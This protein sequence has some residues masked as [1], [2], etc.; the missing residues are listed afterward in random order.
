MSA[1]CDSLVDQAGRLCQ[2]HHCE[3]AIG[4]LEAAV[5]LDPKSAILHY[6]LGFCYS[7]GCQRHLLSDANVALP[8]LRLARTQASAS[9]NPL[10]MARVLDAMG[11]VYPSVS[12][13]SERARLEAAVECHSQAAGLYSALG[14]AEDWSREEFNA[15]NVWC[16][17]PEDAHPDKWDRAIALYEECLRARNKR[18]GPEQYAA[19][20][21]NLGTAYREQR[22]GDPGK[23]VR[24]AIHCY[25]EALRACRPLSELRTAALQHN[26]GNAFLSLAGI[27]KK[28][29][30]R[31]AGRAV[32]HFNQAL[33]IYSRSGHPKEYARTQFSRGQAYALLA[34]NGSQ[35]NRGA[36][37]VCFKE[38]RDCF[39]LDPDSEA[40]ADA[41]SRFLQQITNSAAGG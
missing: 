36:A 22:R 39:A 10:L 4:A 23:S 15:G 40:L 35:T 2:I 26:L 7:G 5:R 14:L 27:E 25:H 18:E 19:T 33:K 8:H 30:S 21:Q 29:D 13:L 38:A 16:D 37:A 17:L 3:E 28:Q 24:K 9:A 32:R 41:A 6:E 11:N 34:S 12:G 20:M 1:A 31:H